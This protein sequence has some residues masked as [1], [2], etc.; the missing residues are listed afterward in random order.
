MVLCPQQGCDTR[1]GHEDWDYCYMP[2][3][4]TLC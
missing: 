1:A 3:I 2:F 4:I